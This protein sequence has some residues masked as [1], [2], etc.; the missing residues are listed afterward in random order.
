[1]G[2]LDNLWIN[3]LATLRLTWSNVAL[4]NGHRPIQRN[5][6]LTA[7]F[8]DQTH[9]SIGLHIDTRVS[10]RHGKRVGV[11]STFAPAP[12]RKLTSKTQKDDNDSHQFKQAAISVD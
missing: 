1:M 8:T 5:R 7:R 9:Q 6:Q 12:H 11:S 4:N 10:Y 3:I 2:D